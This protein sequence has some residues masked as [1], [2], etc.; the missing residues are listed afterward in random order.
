MFTQKEGWYCR[1]V[2]EW[3]AYMIDDPPQVLW[4]KSGV[5]DF[6]LPVVRAQVLGYGTSDGTLIVGGFLKS[7]GKCLYW[8]W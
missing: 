1:G 6:N 4:E 8:F 5:G 3:S 2:G 7:D